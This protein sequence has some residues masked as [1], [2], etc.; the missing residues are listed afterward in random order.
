MGDYHE[1]P[2]TCKS[3]GYRSN[4]LADKDCPIDW[5]ESLWN[6][7]VCNRCADALESKSVALNN[8]RAIEI[9]LSKTN[10]LR[11]SQT[12]PHQHTTLHRFPCYLISAVK[13]AKSSQRNATQSNSTHNTTRFQLLSPNDF[14]TRQPKPKQIKPKQIKPSQNTTRHQ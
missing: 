2:Y 12:K 6:S 9:R 8:L 7:L 11:A 1:V 10:Q 3:C 14:A 5:T 4:A 13:Q